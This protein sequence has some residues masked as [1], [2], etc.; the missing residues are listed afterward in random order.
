M[1]DYTV[2]KPKDR[3]E[4]LKSDGEE[5][6]REFCTLNQ[7]KIPKIVYQKLD[8]KGCYF[9]GRN[10]LYIDP[11]NCRHPT[12]TPGFSWSYPGYTA[13]MTIIGVIAH[14]FGHYY[15]DNYLR[16]NQIKSLPKNKKVSS[17]EPNLSERLAETMRLFITN[18]DLLKQLNPK[19]YKVLADKWNLK[20]LHNQTWKEVLKFAHI[21]YHNAIKNK[22]KK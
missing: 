9:W 11:N 20:P 18:P 6:I 2:F 14:E 22:I 8:S 16:H 15:E 10:T 19:R 3:K 13:D 1:R 17:Y 21:K 4:I 12:K 7:L 5:L